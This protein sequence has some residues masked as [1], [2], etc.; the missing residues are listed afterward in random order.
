MAVVEAILFALLSGDLDDR[1]GSQF[2]NDEAGID[3]F[4]LT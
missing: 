1:Q 3:R 2:L 4:L